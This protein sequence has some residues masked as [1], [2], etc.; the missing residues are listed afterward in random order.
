M[1]RPV[2]KKGALIEM[3]MQGPL[4]VELKARARVSLLGYSK[5]RATIEME[6]KGLFLR[7]LCRE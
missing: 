6:S 1:A 2:A 7:R 4:V 3:E 5:E